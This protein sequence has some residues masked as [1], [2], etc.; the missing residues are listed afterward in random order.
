[1]NQWKMVWNY[2]LG[3]AQCYSPDPL[4][5]TTPDAHLDRAS[6]VTMPPPSGRSCQT[7]PCHLPLPSSTRNPCSIASTCA[8]PVAVA[9]L[10]LPPSRAACHRCCTESR[11]RAPRLQL[12]SW[13]PSSCARVVPWRPLRG[14]SMPVSPLPWTPHRRQLPPITLRRRCHQLLPDTVLPTDP[15]TGTIDLSSG[16]S[17]MAPLHRDAP[18]LKTLFR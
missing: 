14:P 10:S 18:S 8:T 7:A 15:S 1:L 16:R 12:H 17:P 13:V 9:P 3:P 6:V 4:K 11:R 5:P 2:E